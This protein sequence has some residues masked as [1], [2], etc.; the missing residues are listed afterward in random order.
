MGGCHMSYHEARSVF[1]SHSNSPKHLASGDPKAGKGGLCWGVGGVGVLNGRIMLSLDR[2]EEAMSQIIHGVLYTLRREGEG[3]GA[4]LST[5]TEDS[6]WKMAQLPRQD[7]DVI[8]VEH[9]FPHAVSCAARVCLVGGKN[10]HTPPTCCIT[11][12]PSSAVPAG[13]LPSE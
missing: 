10:E 8:T 7:G 4:G 12:R 2:P 5:A 11:F 1:C 3:I 6:L 9:A 13:M